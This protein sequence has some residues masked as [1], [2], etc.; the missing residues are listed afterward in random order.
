M[1]VT[2]ICDY[3]QRV[4]NFLIVVCA[5]DCR[6]MGHWP[7]KDKNEV[8]K[9]RLLRFLSSTMD[10]KRQYGVPFKFDCQNQIIRVSRRILPNSIKSLSSHVV[11]IIS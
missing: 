6:N 3:V 2:D 9:K 7:A 8:H 1:A 4:Q 11:G 10:S 5:K